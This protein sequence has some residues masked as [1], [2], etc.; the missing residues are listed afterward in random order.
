MHVTARVGLAVVEAEVFNR[1]GHP[2][3]GR[4]TSR[5]HRPPAAGF[6][7]VEV[8]IVVM[9]IGIAAVVALPMLGDSHGTRLAAAARLLMA[10]LAFA[11]VESIAHPDDPCVIVFDQAN[12]A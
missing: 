8:L 4:S 7:L 12:A 11:Q 2:M 1:P 3:F 9:V 10:D 5:R 6:T